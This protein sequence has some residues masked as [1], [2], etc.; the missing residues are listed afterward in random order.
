LDN[1]HYKHKTY[2]KIYTPVFEIDGW[3]G[4]DG[5]PSK[6]EAEPEVIEAEPE[7]VEAEVVEPEPEPEVVEEAPKRRRRRKS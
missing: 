4:L 2:G 1:D 5:I 7:V 6:E 3:S